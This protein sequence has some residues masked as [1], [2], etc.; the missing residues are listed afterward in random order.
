MT[1]DA[2]RPDLAPLPVQVRPRHG[3]TV[4]SYI[5]RLARANHLRPSYLHALVR[6]TTYNGTV[7]A[8]H[9][10]ALSGRPARALQH[11]ITGLDRHPGNGPQPAVTRRAATA[12]NDS[13]AVAAIRRDAAA[14]ATVPVRV[15]AARHQV[16]RRAVIQALTPPA[17]QPRWPYPAL[18][19][20]RHHIDA[21]L[22]AEPG[23]SSHKIWQ[24]LIDEHDAEF[25]YGTVSTYVNKRHVSDLVPAAGRITVSVHDRPLSGS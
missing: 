17:S 24:R 13:E 9:L 21:W 22:T 8:D 1:A 5:R 25:G 18:V 11:T 14:D 6:S 3:E 23:I 12:G 19:H 4:H 16:P 7:R 2:A 10:A 15:L 20:V